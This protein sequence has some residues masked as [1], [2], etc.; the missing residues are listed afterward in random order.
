MDVN[1][2]IQNLVAKIQSQEKIIDG[3]IARIKALEA[4]VAIYKNKKN[5]NNSHT[6]PSK[7]ENRLMKN[8]SLREKSD[9][10]AGVQHGHEGKTLECSSMIDIIVET[11]AKLLQLLRARFN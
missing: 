5:S 8:Q 11:Q 3:L 1:L 4:E 9:K 6:P 10:K 2:V 7:D